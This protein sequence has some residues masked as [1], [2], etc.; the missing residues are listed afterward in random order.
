MLKILGG[1]FRSR[2]LQS[3]PDGETTRPYLARVR[4]S[5][6]NL[7][8]GWC[9]DASVLDLFAGVGTIG[10]ET[11]SRGARMV[12]MI[13][14]DRKIF[15]ML[16]ANVEALGCGDRVRL[17]HGDAL[18]PGV[19]HQAAA[20]VDLLFVDPP[21]PVML[22]EAG[23]TRVLEQI[24]RAREIMAEPGFVILRTPQRPEGPEWSLAG[25]DGPE[26]HEYG[27]SMFVLLYGPAPAK[28]GGGDAGETT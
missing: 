9:D 1:D 11:V 19:I 10:L 12:V 26:V 7:L 6:F 15:R 17:V 14:R 27:K 16:Q 25:Y 28:S 13:E 3:P 22:E 8:R 24:V 21:Y 4:E 23:R 18:S 5:L 20:P 2:R